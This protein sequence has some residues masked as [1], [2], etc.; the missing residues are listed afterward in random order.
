M[1]VSWVE[2]TDLIAK[3]S[4]EIHIG[5]NSLTV[6]R[7]VIQVDICDP[8]ASTL[9]DRED[10]LPQM[11]NLSEALCRFEK[12]LVIK[13]NHS[14]ILKLG[15]GAHSALLKVLGIDHVGMGNPIAV[16]KFLRK[17]RER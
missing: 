13:Y 14:T 10:I 3:G 4:M 9:F 1:F 17:W 12:T 2:L 16:Y 6:T 7:D 8:G 15:K 5:E 11:K